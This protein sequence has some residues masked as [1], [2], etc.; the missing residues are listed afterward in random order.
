MASAANLGVRLDSLGRLL[1]ETVCHFGREQA[2][3]V[4]IVLDKRRSSGVLA[5]R[6]RLARCII[7]RKGRNQDT[8]GFMYIHT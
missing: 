3:G 4:G 8:I 6:L 7:Y 2:E 5:I 1:V